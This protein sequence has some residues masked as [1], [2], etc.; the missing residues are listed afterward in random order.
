M[1]HWLTAII[2]LATLALSACHS[3]D[4]PVEVSVDAAPIDNARPEK[5]KCDCRNQRCRDR[6][7]RDN[8]CPGRV[9][10][11]CPR[12]VCPDGMSYEGCAVCE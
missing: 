10:L 3:T 2:V 9:G 6:W 12:W 5:D 11:Q 7:V 1:R 8:W 4:P